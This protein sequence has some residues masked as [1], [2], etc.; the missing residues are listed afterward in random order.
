MTTKSGSETGGG[1]EVQLLTFKLDDQE[2]ALDITNVVQ[3]VRMVAITPIPKAPEVVEGV[4]NLRGKVIPVI[5]LRQR[6]GLPTRPYGLNDHLLIARIN[7]QVMALI[8]DVVSEMLT[9]P[10]SDLDFTSEIGPQKMEFISGVGRLNDK[11]ILVL[12]PNVLLACEDQQRL[13]AAL[14]STSSS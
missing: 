8:V 7:D 9:L 2:Y 1:R 6:C 11:L 3:V 4:I 10:M 12:D 13:T 5:N 14:A